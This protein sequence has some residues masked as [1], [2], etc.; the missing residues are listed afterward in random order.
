M[1]LGSKTHR[2]APG[3]YAHLPANQQHTVKASTR[4]RVAVIEKPAISLLNVAPAAALFGNE[5][6]VASQPLGGD[7]HC[8]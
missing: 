2:L 7:M 5:D 6:D 4:S 8:K 1:A 3:G